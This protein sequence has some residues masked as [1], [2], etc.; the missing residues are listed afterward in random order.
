MHYLKAVL[1][2]LVGGV[3][4]TAAILVIEVVYVEQVMAA[5]LADCGYESNASAGG[6]CFGY[7]QF[8]EWMVPV[9]FVVGFT[10]VFF[11]ALRRQPQLV[12]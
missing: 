10:A 8:R 9:A 11:W 3:L 5:R 1:V 4:L 7:L 2:G 6:V 12:A